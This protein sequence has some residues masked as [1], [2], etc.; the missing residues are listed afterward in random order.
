MLW[1]YKF[2]NKNADGRILIKIWTPKID[3]IVMGMNKIRGGTRKI[4]K[5]ENLT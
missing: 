2:F 4:R 5:T 3:E 1:Q